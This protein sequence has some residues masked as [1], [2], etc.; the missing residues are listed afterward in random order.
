MQYNAIQCKIHP[1]FLFRLE[2][3]GHRTGGISNSSTAR[4]R[5]ARRARFIAVGAT[6]SVG[7]VGSRGWTRKSWKLAN[8][9]GVNMF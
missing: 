5:W 3:L 6:T 2:E 1:R 9:N 4:D 8:P 7:C